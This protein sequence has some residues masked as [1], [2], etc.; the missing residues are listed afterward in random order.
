MLP[1]V[2]FFLPLFFGVAPSKKFLG[3]GVEVAQL[4]QTK[5]TSHATDYFKS[6]KLDH[7]EIWLTS[8]KTYPPGEIGL[9]GNQYGTKVSGMAD[10]NWA[11]FFGDYNNGQILMKK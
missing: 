8:I 7:E 4:P 10:F 3:G 9:R 11:T 2:L 5:Y 6:N 1:N